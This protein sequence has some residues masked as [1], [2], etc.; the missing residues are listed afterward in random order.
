MLSDNVNKLIFAHININSIR[1]NLQF[2][3]L[4]VKGK[5][6]ILMILETKIDESFLRAIFLIAGFSTTLINL[7]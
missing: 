1:N 4:Q 6:D 7:K 5:T 2:S 3:A